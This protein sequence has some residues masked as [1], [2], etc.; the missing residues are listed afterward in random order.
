MGY[1]SNYL[2]PRIVDKILST[3]RVSQYRKEIL[4]H[5]IGEILEIGFGTGLN[6]SYYPAWVKEITVIDNNE[7]MNSLAQK[8]VKHSKINVNLKLLNAEILPFEDKSFDSIVSTFTFCSIE[9]IDSALKEIYRVLKPDGKLIFLE[10]GLSSNKKL[11]NLQHRLNPLYKVVSGGCNLNRDMKD[12]IERNNFKF[13]FIEEFTSK[14]MS[15][16]TGY[17]YKGI[18]IKRGTFEKFK[19][20]L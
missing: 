13:D 10:H 8:R 4:S 19:L 1:Y 2:Y 3:S 9:N 20:L 12:V 16:L 7:G 6:L 18:A 11:R 5:V 15:K 17:L 14:D